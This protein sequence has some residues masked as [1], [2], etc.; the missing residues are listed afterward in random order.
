M[1]FNVSVRKG[2]QLLRLCM[3]LYIVKCVMHDS[4]VCIAS[5]VMSNNYARVHVNLMNVCVHISVTLCICMHLI[6]CYYSCFAQA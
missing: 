1:C 3:H 4:C 6:L 5:G 2:I